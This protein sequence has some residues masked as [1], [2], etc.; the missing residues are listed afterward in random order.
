M[1]TSSLLSDAARKLNRQE[2]LSRLSVGTSFKHL[3]FAPDVSPLKPAR[4]SAKCRSIHQDD[5]P[6]L[7]FGDVS[8]R[9][10]GARLVR[11]KRQT[12]VVPCFDSGVDGPFCA[13]CA[14]VWAHTDENDYYLFD[15]QSIMP[16]AGRVY[17]EGQFR[18]L[19][20][21]PLVKKA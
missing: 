6:F 8:H 13:H 15:P 4:S 7:N 19:F 1:A 12:V 3:G 10:S 11:F 16:N 20:H 9:C 14:E 21:L 2:F 5:V 18:V 17:A